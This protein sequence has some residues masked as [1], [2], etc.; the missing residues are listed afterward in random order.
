MKNIDVFEAPD[1]E[2]ISDSSLADIAW[3]ED[4]REYAFRFKNPIKTG[5]INLLEQRLSSCYMAKVGF[6]AHKDKIPDMKIDPEQDH[7]RWKAFSNIDTLR[8]ETKR[9]LLEKLY[10]P[11]TQYL[12]NSFAKDI[13]DYAKKY[14]TIDGSRRL[15]KSNEAIG[16]V[17]VTNLHDCS[18]HAL[19][20]LG[21]ILI[22]GKL[23][24]DERNTA[25]A[26]LAAWL[27]TYAAGTIQAFI[28]HFNLRSQKFFSR[29]GFEPVCLHVF[30]PNK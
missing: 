6:V 17:T 3:P 19:D 12:D 16:I 27:K 14:V 15:M 1:I 8:A 18:G 24:D 9:T 28:H 5:T 20:H 2:D 10:Y 13:D 26:K 11:N 25:H 21:W 30:K 4:I 23:S 29:L 22:D 7:I